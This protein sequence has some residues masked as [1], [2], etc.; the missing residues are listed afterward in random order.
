[1]RG[2][3]RDL[4]YNKHSWSGTIEAILRCVAAYQELLTLLRS[5]PGKTSRT[6]L[7]GMCR[8]CSRNVPR[9]YI[10]G[11]M[12]WISS[13]TI[14]RIDPATWHCTCFW[15]TFP[16]PRSVL[17]RDLN[18]LHF[19]GAFAARVQLCPRP[20]RGIRRGSWEILR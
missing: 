16:H 7:T 14:Y 18:F 11:R 5:A 12:P 10:S 15:M 20:P 9:M 19:K 13:R 3:I 8:R 1:M 2:C 4:Y 17:H 6:S